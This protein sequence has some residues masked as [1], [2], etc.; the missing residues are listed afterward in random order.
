MIVGPHAPTSRASRLENVTEHLTS[1][2]TELLH[3]GRHTL[4]DIIN[5]KLGQLSCFVE[6]DAS[7]IVLVEAISETTLE[8]QTED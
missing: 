8:P 5:F 2:L 1:L 6:V 3:V 4:I 7:H